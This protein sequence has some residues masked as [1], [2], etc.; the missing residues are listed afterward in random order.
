MASAGAIPTALPTASRSGDRR[1]EAHEEGV[2]HELHRGRGVDPLAEI[3]QLA[4]HRRE[5]RGDPRDAVAIARHQHESGA[6]ASVLR[7]HE[8]RGRGRR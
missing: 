6:V 7:A 2:A 8:H 3:E 5:Q 1:G 4:G